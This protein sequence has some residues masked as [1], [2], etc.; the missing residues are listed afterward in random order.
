M[1]RFRS[2]IGLFVFAAVLFAFSPLA[3]AQQSA[4]AAQQ[5]PPPAAEAA[6]PTISLPASPL[7]PLATQ[8]GQKLETLVTATA[9]QPPPN[10][11]GEDT[12][13]QITDTFTTGVLNTLAQTI[14]TL[15]ANSANLAADIS[16]LPD[17]IDWLNHQ[18]T[19]PHRQAL[20][21]AIGGD[22]LIIVGVPLLSGIAISLLLMPVIIRLRRN[23]P[24]TRPGRVGLLFSL[25]LLRLVPIVI[26]FGAALVLLDQNETHRLPRF[27]ILNIIY[28][29]ALAQTMHQS[30]RCI[31]AP[32]AE[33]LR[34]F[35]LT[36]PR[37]VYA[38]RWLSAYSFVLVYGYFFVDIASAL[39][40]PD[41]AIII[42]QNIFGLM[43]TVMT[44][45][46]I[47][48]TR[49]HVASILRGNAEEQDQQ[50]FNRAMR[51]WLARRWHILT[52]AYLVIG[53]AVSLLGIDHGIAVMLRG[54]ILTLTILTSARFGFIVLDIWKMPKANASP[55][56]HRQIL[57]FLLRPVIWVSAVVGIAA[58]WGF[59]FDG[60]LVT[61]SGQRTITALISIALTLFIL[62]A[63]YEILNSSIER[64]LNRRDKITKQ[65]IATARARTLLPMM[66]NIIFI[67]FSGI[68]ILSFLAAV[69]VNIG[70]LLAGA[71][72]IGVAIGF[73][74]QSLVKDFLTGLFIVAENSVAVGDV[75]TIGAF[76]GVVEAL[77]IRTIRLRDTDGSLYIIPF[78]EVSK[79][80]NMTKGFAYAL[81]DVGVAY[82]S[83]LERVMNVLR[84]I[85]AQIQADP[86][87]KR[88]ILEPIEVM[89]IEKFGDSSITIRSRIRTRPGK[90]WD[91]RRLLML[92]IQ[93]RF[94]KENIDMPFP[95]AIS[96]TKTE[97]V[98]VPSR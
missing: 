67:F 68:A 37:A 18:N 83:D 38:Y 59:R 69:G 49:T 44:I 32:T 81:V 51:M 72:V 84:D 29:L 95:T 30:L 25:F 77:S 87:F 79:I 92:R 65:P 58:T 33:H 93:Q 42:L 5:T 27:V 53:L 73:G 50:S 45:I 86:V 61:P 66:R 12:T 80:T 4:A 82:D 39:R 16:A 56:I 60:F 62:T 55:L 91:V 6:K 24:L 47:F 88:V 34:P 98:Q 22:L 20:W 36:T 17:F 76:S 1:T 26:F 8:L 14:N 46:V 28:A 2:F 35:T 89:G 31:F 75:V 48:Q 57:A 11:N 54:T 70:P 40:V 52:T 21:S 71:G 94:A 96:I 85:G 9:P 7:A 74:S 63:I 19:D 64:H 13:G 78:S 15:K 43:L 3:H 41:N 23:H 97:A 90:Q 10:D